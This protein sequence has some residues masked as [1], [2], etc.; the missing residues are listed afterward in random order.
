MNNYYPQSFKSVTKTRARAHIL[1]SQVL[2]KSLHEYTDFLRGTNP[3]QH[4]L[5]TRRLPHEDWSECTRSCFSEQFF[6][7]SKFRPYPKTHTD[8]LRAQSTNTQHHRGAATHISIYLYFTDI[9]AHVFVWVCVDLYICM[10]V[11]V[12]IISVYTIISNHGRAHTYTLV[13]VACTLYLS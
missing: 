6:W 4:K 11:C 7:F 1:S 13:V 9:Y 2:Y 12:Y 3:S 5:I 8:F 10:C